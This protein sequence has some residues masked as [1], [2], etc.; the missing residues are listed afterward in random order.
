[1]NCIV[2]NAQGAWSRGFRRA[3]RY[4]LKHFK[5]YVLALL[6]PQVSGYKAQTVCDGLG[7]SNN[8][9]VEVVGTSGG[10]WLLWNDC[11]TSVQII[12]DF[13]SFIHAKVDVSSVSY[14]LIVDYG[15]PTPARR[16]Q[17]WD[18]LDRTIAS[19]SKPCFIG[20]DFNVIVSLSERQGGSGAVVR[21]LPVVRSDHNP[22]L[23]SLRPT[24][25]LNPLRRPFRFEAM[26]LT[27]PDCSTF[28]DRNWQRDISATAA[29]RDDLLNKDKFGNVFA[30]K[31]ELFRR[32]QGIDSAIANG[33]PICLMTLQNKL[34]TELEAVLLQEEMFWFQKAR[35]KWIECGDRNTTFFHTSTV[36]R[37]RR[38]RISVLKDS[39]ENRVTD[40]DMLESMVVDYFAELF[41][42]PVAD[43]DSNFLPPGGF[44]RISNTDLLALSTPF[45][46][47][48]IWASVRRMGAYKS[49]RID[50]FQPVFYHSCWDIVNVSVC[51][52]IRAFFASGQLPA[53]VNA[54]IIHLIGKVAHPELVSQFRP[55]SL[56]NV[57]Y[58]MITKI[59]AHR[60]QPIMSKLVGPTQSSFILGRVISD[61]VVLV[62]EIVHSMSHKSGRKGWMLIKLD[63]EKA[64]DR[65]QWDFIED[66]LK[67]VGLPDCWV[68][69]IMECI[70]TSSMRV[71][72][73]GELT[74]VFS[75]S[76]G[77]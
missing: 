8:F 57:L 70:S 16:D 33:G 52:F 69:W 42:L 56:C 7:F 31:D 32:I 74:R 66:T 67:N 18:E 3:C 14:H 27:H 59:L 25:L 41:T 48:E 6:E 13:A 68:R 44:P 11:D 77:I 46:D 17:F 38:N 62:Q 58:K 61:N 53:E 72:W 4:M 50:G 71:L 75:P 1:M 5:T 35:C 43:R 36:I 15:P 65:L 47:D 45:K 10:V 60:L 73:N 76:R 49:P 30:K 20:G 64:Y 28:I 54:T 29:L 37:R 24:T 55:I 21:H 22:L 19:I 39:T 63:L 40:S 12:D 2:W 51:N 23:L 26:W 34:R 9:R